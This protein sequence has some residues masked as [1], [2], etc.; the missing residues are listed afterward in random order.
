MR[1]GGHR[2]DESLIAAHIRVSEQLVLDREVEGLAVPR[3]LTRGQE[4]QSRPVRPQDRLGP[5]RP[6][7]L[8]NAEQ[9]AFPLEQWNLVFEELFAC[10]FAG[11]RRIGDALGRT[12]N[13][14]P[15]D[16]PVN[17]PRQNQGRLARLAGDRQGHFPV[18][19]API[20]QE[21]EAD[22]SDLLL[23]RHQGLTQQAGNLTHRRAE[24]RPIQPSRRRVPG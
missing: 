14:R 22:I 1:L 6:G 13:V 24:G 3:I 5:V 15:P 10:V 12:E 8:R 19:R 7:H 21:L 2:W 23:P 16:S 17:L 11:L 9:P 20:G 4:N 18:G